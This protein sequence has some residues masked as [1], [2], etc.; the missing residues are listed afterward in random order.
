[1]SNQVLIDTAI[2][3]RY[4]TRTTKLM[5]LYVTRQNQEFV[6]ENDQQLVDLELIRSKVTLVGEPGAGDWGTVVQGYNGASQVSYR[7]TINSNVLQNTAA[8]RVKQRSDIDHSL[9]NISIAGMTQQR[10]FLGDE[11]HN[12]YLSFVCDTDLGIHTTNAINFVPQ[13]CENVKLQQKL[14]VHT[15][16]L[17]NK[18]LEERKGSFVED[19][20]DEDVAT[21]RVEG[22]LGSPVKYFNTEATTSSDACLVP[23]NKIIS[24]LLTFKVTPRLDV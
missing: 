2:M 24:A 21:R 15:D 17:G 10:Q 8:N 19:W 16:F 14:V 22:V 3:K 13:A 9:V 6:I 4:Q 18:A 1:M 12:S 7:N 5:H 23:S 20:A 11:I